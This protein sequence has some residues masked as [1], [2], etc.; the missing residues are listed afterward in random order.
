MNRP[1][2]ISIIAIVS[3]ING[4]IQIFLALGFGLSSMSTTVQQSVTVS[5]A[6]VQLMSAI[7]FITGLFSIIYGLGMWR[8]RAWSWWLAVIVNLF[9]LLHQLWFVFNGNGSVSIDH[10]VSLIVAIVLLA[11]LNSKHVKSAFSISK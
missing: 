3:I 9:N 10:W 1:I 5:V 7:L 2:L 8:L 4:I 6:G 11:Y